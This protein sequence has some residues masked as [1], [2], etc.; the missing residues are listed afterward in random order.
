MIYLIFDFKSTCFVI[1][2]TKKGNTG[3]RGAKGDRGFPGERG[4][5][6]LPGM[7]G[8]PGLKGDTGKHDILK[9]GFIYV[10][11]LISQN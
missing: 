2:P 4:P 6:G 5:V 8:Y 10:C 1:T 9:Y 7:S 11:H 3:M